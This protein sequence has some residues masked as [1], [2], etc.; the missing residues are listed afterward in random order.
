MK[1]NKRSVGILG[2]TGM[3]GQKL[4]EMLIDH[5]WFEIT[6]LAASER[7]FGK[8]YRD[9]VSWRMSVPLPE[10]IGKLRVCPCIPDLPCELVFSGLDSGVAGDI[11]EEFAMAGYV[12]V[13]NAGNHR[14]GED[15][16][17]IIPEIN[18]DHLA[19][20]RKQR[21][22]GGIIITNPN[23][24]VVGLSMALKPL[25][26]NFGVTAVHVVTL[27]AMSGA[28]LP[29]IPGIQI[30]DNVIPYISDEEGKISREPQKIFG[31]YN[32]D[33]IEYS[34]MIIS[35]HCNRVPVVDGHLEC[36]SVRL[37]SPASRQNIIDAWRGFPGV[38]LPTAPTRPVLYFEDDYF[39]QPKLQSSIGNGMTVGIGRLRE[40]P[41]LGYKFIVLVNNTV[42]GAAGCAILNAE[43]Y[44]KTNAKKGF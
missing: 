27:Q 7:S 20:A 43:L 42:R 39:P 28:G 22:G 41:V 21:Y 23:C 17:L 2:A 36:V 10:R 40:C 35:A 16:P 38:D 30:L 8:D 4:I 5:P 1:E 24:S 9:A 44:T 6:A 29:G 31:T 19:L 37:A 11:E 14:L 18:S 13:S 3:V 33:G 25:V 26:D 15:I 12:V 32:G 34:D